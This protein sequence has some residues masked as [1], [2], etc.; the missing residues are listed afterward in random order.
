VHRTVIEK[1]YISHA[2]SAGLPDAEDDPERADLLAD[3]LAERSRLVWKP[4][5]I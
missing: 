5:R 1:G 2:E 4:S 3:L